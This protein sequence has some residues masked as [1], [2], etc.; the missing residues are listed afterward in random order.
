MLWYLLP[1]LLNFVRRNVLM[2][3]QGN[4]KVDLEVIGFPTMKLTHM[5]YGYPIVLKTEPVLQ[6]NYHKDN[7]KVLLKRVT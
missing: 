5:K 2:L 3:T 4:L 6:G 1:S 7:L